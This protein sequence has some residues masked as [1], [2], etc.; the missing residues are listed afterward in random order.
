MTATSVAP[1]E[2]VAIL[3]FAGVVFGAACFDCLGNPPQEPDPAYVA[4]GIRVEHD[5]LRGVTCW[6]S[7]VGLSCLPD[8]QI[9]TLPLEAE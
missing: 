5:D 3:L 4:P 9:L 7:N 6:R 2:A 1:L 8:S